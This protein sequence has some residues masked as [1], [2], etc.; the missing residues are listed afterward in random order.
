LLLAGGV[1]LAY[2]IFQ[3]LEGL[4]GGCLVQLEFFCDSLGALADGKQ[5]WRALDLASNFLLY[6]LQQVEY[7]D[8][9]GLVFSG[10]LVKGALVDPMPPCVCRCTNSAVLRA[11]S[12]SVMRMPSKAARSRS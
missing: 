7:F 11:S 4:L 5:V 2:E 6:A 8:R 10:D 9:V 12:R 3:F 1:D